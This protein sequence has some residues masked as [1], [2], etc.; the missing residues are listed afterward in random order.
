MTVRY[1]VLGRHERLMSE[2]VSLRGAR[3]EF[4]RLVR[5]GE[6]P[7]AIVET[8]PLREFDL[9]SFVREDAAEALT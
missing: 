2:H 7:L 9:E 3:R 5:L 1:Q 4:D 8:V 6:G